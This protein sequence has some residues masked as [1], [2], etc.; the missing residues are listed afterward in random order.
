MSST[1]LTAP[2]RPP[3]VEDFPLLFQKISSNVSLAQACRE[4]NLH[5]YTVQSRLAS[6]K[7]LA[8]EYMLARAYRGDLLAERALETAEKVLKGG[9]MPDGGVDARAG[10]VAIDTFQWG[11]SQLSPKEWGQS[12]V[13]QE[14]TGKDGKEINI[15]NQVVVFM[16]PDNGR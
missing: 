11:A 8:R 6:D 2:K 14:V 1:S 16:L 12:T 10:K 5:Y 13:R 4:L 15:G 7:D 9:E 3:R